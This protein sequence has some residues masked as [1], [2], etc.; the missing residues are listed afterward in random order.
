ME[1]DHDL[2]DEPGIRHRTK[3]LTI[4]REVQCP[5]DNSTLVK[6]S[7]ITIFHIDRVKDKGKIHVKPK[8][9]NTLQT[10]GELWSK[11]GKNLLNDMSSVFYVRDIH[12]QLE[13]HII[14]N[15]RVC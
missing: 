5:D 8:L 12:T 9:S 4:H 7:F 3:Q 6:S 13:I 14:G 2:I 10:N 11:I 1:I 15:R